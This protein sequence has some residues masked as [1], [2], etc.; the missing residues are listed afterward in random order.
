MHLLI[1][2]EAGRHVQDLIQLQHRDRFGPL[3]VV[4]FHQLL[5]IER[6]AHEN[7]QHFARTRL[8]VTDDLRVVDVELG[9]AVVPVA[10]VLEKARSEL[11]EAAR[12][13]KCRAQDCAQKNFLHRLINT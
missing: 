3:Q 2:V 1:D 9:F 11:R 6:L 12:A 7:M 5:R 10:V 4:R 8:P 13:E